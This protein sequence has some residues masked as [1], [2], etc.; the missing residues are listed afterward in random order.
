MSLSYGFNKSERQD[1]FNTVHNGT[2]V[3]ED[4]F[5]ILNPGMAEAMEILQ[6]IRDMKAHSVLKGED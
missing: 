4:L 6:E 1:H 5:T 2:E 3:T